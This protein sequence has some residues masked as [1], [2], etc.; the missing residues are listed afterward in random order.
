MKKKRVIAVLLSAAMVATGSQ[1]VPAA[2]SNQEKLNDAKNSV[3]ALE[4][5]TS[6]IESQL[7]DL[8]SDLSECIVNITVTKR[9][10]A[11]T[12]AKL[13]K[14]KAKLAKAKQDEREQYAA[15]K[16]R[17]RMQYENS[18]TTALTA[19]FS[20]KNFG[21]TLNKTQYASTVYN[22]DQDIRKTYKATVRRVNN[23]VD[24]VQEKKDELV[25]TKESYE[26]EKA[27]LKSTISKKKSQLSNFNS[28]L[29][30]AKSLARKYAA[31]VEAEN[32][33]AQKAEAAA[34]TASSSNG[35]ASSSGASSAAS[36]DSESIS[37]SS[38]SG[39]QS[40]S[41]NISSSD[42]SGSQSDSENISSSDTSGSTPDSENI[43]S[44]DTGGSYSGR[45]GS[46][47]ISYASQFVG[48]RYVW[49]GTSLT[50][51]CDCSGFVMS[52]YAHFGV[53]LPHSSSALRSVGRAVSQSS[54]Q[55]G[56]IV[57]YAGHVGLYAGNGKLLNASNSAPYPRGGIKY[58]N[59][60]YRTILAVR[61]IF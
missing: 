57:C 15:M 25:D 38:T 33:A 28:Q 14:A 7:D 49:G 48:N 18:G 3:A 30:E 35:T 40:D 43:S 44:S 1:I 34:S 16:K 9:D 46:A 22:N 6:S 37:S 54:M 23:L 19:I 52:V 60:H 51:G 58:T 24:E 31:A 55:P 10:L 8:D 21:D 61:R 41:E 26:H 2:T 11:K 53:S 20:S 39:S 47:V 36:G 5:K 29:S 50:N 32:E 17:I 12:R 42:T 27:N 56:D 4:K 13:K 59:V 45:S